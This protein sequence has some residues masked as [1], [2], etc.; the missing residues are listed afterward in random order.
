MV[1]DNGKTFVAATQIIDSVPEVQ[2]HFV[3]LRVKWVFN[4]E[5]A[6]WSGV[7]FVQIMKWCLRKAVGKARLT[8]DELV[9]VLTLRL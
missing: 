1:S 6:P 3:G 4:L 9:T 7:F 8:H 2:E 5:N